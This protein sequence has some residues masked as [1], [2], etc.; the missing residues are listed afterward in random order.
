MI[1][2]FLSWWIEQLSA[3]V[4]DRLR[5]FG[6]RTA[7]AVVLALEDTAVVATVR[8]RG[9]VEALG[10]F[11]KDRRGAT[12]LTSALER[13]RSR[14]PDV[15]FQPPPGQVLRKMMS[16][17]LVARR[18]LRQV[19]EFEM[20]H[21]TPFGADE[22]V[23]DYRIRRQDRASG[24]LDVELMFIPRG[25]FEA[26]RGHVRD[27]GLSG[28]A[29]EICDGDGAPSRIDLDHAAP[30]MSGGGHRLAVA[31]AALFLLL[32][33]AAAALPFVRLE[34]SLVALREESQRL[35]E[36]AATT[37]A[38]KKE[39]ERLSRA[40][41]FFAAE[42]LR[43]RDPL[44]VTAA[45]TRTLPNDTY[46]TE[47][48][49]HGDRMTVVGLSPSAAGLIAAL[50]ATKPFRDP[51]FGAPVVRPEGNKLELFTINANLEPTGGGQ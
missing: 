4:P 21:E 3:L 14:R 12:A 44:V 17:P 15:V 31:V 46:L 16:F 13:L 1:Q 32:A 30:G 34:Q 33:S 49:L 39:I 42:R 10:R 2:V 6:R 37:L 25:I 8:R 45:A 7:D 28:G 24:R 48:S 26:L 36:A 22:V 47:L 27:A 9:H 40:D 43:V 20:S 18:N 35:H 5:G 38:M 11:D 50:S 19:L 41:N 29:V 23:W 51:A